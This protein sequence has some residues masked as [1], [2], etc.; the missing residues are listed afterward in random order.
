MP[1]LFTKQ[2]PNIFTKLFHVIKP[3]FI[4]QVIRSNIQT[5]LD[6]KSKFRWAWFSIE[7]RVLTLPFL[8][9]DWVTCIVE[10]SP[11]EYALRHGSRFQTCINKIRTWFWL[12]NKAHQ[13]HCYSVWPVV[14]SYQWYVI[15]PSM[16][17]IRW[18]KNFKKEL[19]LQTKNLYRLTNN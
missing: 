14:T 19:Y 8:P 4:I 1:F 6:Y 3:M 15:W 11:S 12:K 16:I 2:F 18:N 5:S 9:V 13:N 7:N 17:Q 10:H